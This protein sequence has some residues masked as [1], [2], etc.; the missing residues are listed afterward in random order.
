MS[1]W[2]KFFS[3]Q[4]GMAK[5]ANKIA[6][7]GIQDFIH[8]TSNAA[9]K[10]GYI[11]SDDRLGYNNSGLLDYSS[12][13]LP[14]NFS[15]DDLNVLQ[16]G[17]MQLGKIYNPIKPNYMYNFSIFGENILKHSLL[18][19]PTGSGKTYGVIVPAIFSLLKN[20]FS[21]I[22]NDV[23][24]DM[25]FHLKEYRQQMREKFSIGVFSFNPFE[26][27]MSQCW[28]P[29]DEIESINDDALINS[30]V[31][32]I[33]GADESQG[34]QNIHF[35]ER[36][37]RWLSALIKIVKL[38]VQSA[39]FND[40][41][42]LVINNSMLRGVIATAP[43]QIKQDL[44]DLINMSNFNMIA[45]LANKLKIFNRQSVSMLMS[46]S[47]FTM[48]YIIN[49]PIL[50][51][52]GCPLSEGEEAFKLTA[53][54]YCVLRNKIY[55]NGQLG[56]PSV[57]I[58]DEAGELA[59]RLELYRDLATIRSYNVGLFL[60]VQQLSQ[61]G[62]KQYKNYVANCANK[63][64]LEGIDYNTAEYFEK[65]FGS[66]NINS[67][68]KTIDRGKD[69]SWSS[70][71]KSVPV[72]SSSALMSYPNDFLEYSGIYYNQSLLGRPVL[73]NFKR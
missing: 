67:I 12:L 37:K 28:N 35:V 45:G 33:I 19:A 34:A 5:K 61:F 50:L 58:I 70:A 41:Y 30:I 11:L 32:V 53:I 16:S 14:K 51:I 39:S 6:Y 66:K 43:I 15:D 40:I 21:V 48:D 10:S 36:D 55:K 17:E 46:K 27:N 31:S 62:E 64:L 72:L 38:K 24:G 7:G 65:A 18:I 73:L 3:L 52:L 25:L 1:F 44:M 22:T 60:S 23:K 71:V 4:Y 59:N 68:S 8:S 26:P 49:N 57:W 20:G 29:L 13:L 2:G 63:I 42:N 47:D 69:M 9:L 54:A 56:V